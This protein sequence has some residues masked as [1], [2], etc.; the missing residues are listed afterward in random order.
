MNIS[1]LIWLGILLYVIPVV[2]SCYYFC[3]IDLKGYGYVS[4]NQL[5]ANITLSVIPF[6]NI[7]FSLATLAEYYKEI[8]DKPIIGDYSK[9]LHEERRTNRK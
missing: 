9:M 6:F 3:K 7:I 1:T 8:L 2:V 4:T 5:I